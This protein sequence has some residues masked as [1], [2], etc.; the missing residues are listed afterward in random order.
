MTGVSCIA[1]ARLRWLWSSQVAY[2]LAAQ[3]LLKLHEALCTANYKLQGTAFT[4]TLP[5]LPTAYRSI[6]PHP[7][8]LQGR[9]ELSVIHLHTLQVL[10]PI[11]LLP[12]CC[13]ACKY[14]YSGQVL[15]PQ[16]RMIILALGQPLW[17]AP[18]GR[19]SPV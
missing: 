14:R 7:S 5:T 8:E 10:L 3:L 4:G 11:A 18:L 1:V 2:P 6:E 15:A 9:H 12:F 13:L 19:C 17:S 16:T